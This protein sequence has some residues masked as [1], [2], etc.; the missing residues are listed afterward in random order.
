MEN[1]FKRGVFELKE[2]KVS[3]AKIGNMGDL[4]NE[5]IIENVLGY[6]V[7]HSNRWKCQTTGI[8]SSLNSFF[9]SNSE[10][11]MSKQLLNKLYGQFHS[12]LQVWSTGFINYSN[13]KH[14]CIRKENYISA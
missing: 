13:E 14:S 9:P 10:L 2:V 6:K 8:G 7:I 5:L 12:P 3:Y 1:L 11:H 4:L